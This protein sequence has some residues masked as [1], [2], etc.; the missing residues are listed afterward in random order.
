MLPAL[1]LASGSLRADDASQTQQAPSPAAPE[2]TA[3]ATDTA[4]PQA[5]PAQGEVAPVAPNTAQPRPSSPAQ[6]Q[7]DTETKAQQTAPKAHSSDLIGA[8]L[9]FGAGHALACLGSAA[10]AT[11]V[12]LWLLPMGPFGWVCVPYLLAPIAL[13]GVNSCGALVPSSTCVGA[14]ASAIWD[15]R[16][17]LP[18]LLGGLPGVLLGGGCAALGMASTTLSFVSLLQDSTNN[19]EPSPSPEWEAWLPLGIVIGTAGS[20]LSGLLTLAGIIVYEKRTD[21]AEESEQARASAAGPAQPRQKFVGD[22]ARPKPAAT[23]VAAY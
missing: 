23:F 3:P 19:N 21:E 15:G 9:G 10:L 18:V 1:L 14:S 12:L 7:P 8:A 13:I 17:C 6:Q 16:N 20:A 22:P 5:T 11:P 2:T 4:S